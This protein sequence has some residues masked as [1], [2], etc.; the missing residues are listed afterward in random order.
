MGRAFTKAMADPKLL[1]EAETL[2]L[3]VSY[4][5]GE[6]AQAI[7]ARAVDAPKGDIDKVREAIRLKPA[8]AQAGTRSP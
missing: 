6:E 1:A 3:P 2:K 8:D 7:V 4:M 5:S